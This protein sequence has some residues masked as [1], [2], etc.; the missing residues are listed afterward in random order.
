M[1]GTSELSHNQ[2]CNVPR[3]FLSS[4]ER[5]ILQGCLILVG[6]ECFTVYSSFP[7]PPD[8]EEPLAD[9]VQSSHWIGLDCSILLSTQSG[10]VL[11][12]LRDTC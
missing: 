2:C 1:Q 5:G 12:S 3:T 4:F 7:D 8:G 9:Q 10:I 6:A 11:G